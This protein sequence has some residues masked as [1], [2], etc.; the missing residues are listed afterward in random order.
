MT[1][2]PNQLRPAAGLILMLAGG[3][4]HAQLTLSRWM[5]TTTP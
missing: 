2:F 3:A 1:R 5:N 4:L